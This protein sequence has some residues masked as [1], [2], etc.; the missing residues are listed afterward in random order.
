MVLA[1]RV[2][3]PVVLESRAFHDTVRRYGVSGS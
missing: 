3:D 2:V 1:Q